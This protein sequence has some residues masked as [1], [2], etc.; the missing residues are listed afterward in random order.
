MLIKNPCSIC[1]FNVHN[2][3]KAIFCD[4]C[5]FWTHLKCTS[6]SSAEYIALSNSPEDWFCPSCIAELF[7][8]NQLDDTD[9]YFALYDFNSCCFD[10]EHLK[11]KCFNPFLDDPD[12]RHLLLN[13]DIDP[14]L[15]V[16]TNNASLLSNCIYL[17]SNEL[18]KIPISSS[19]AFS[20]FHIN[21][22]SLSKHFDD[23]SEYISTLNISFSAI[24]ISETWLNNST[25][26]LFNIPGYNFI[27]NIRQHKSGGGVGLY[28][29]SN[30][31]FKPRIDLQ[32]TD[33]RLYESI[34]AEIIQPNSRNIIVGCIYKPPDTSVTEFN[35]SISSIL[36]TIS[37]ENK[38]SYIMGDFN[39]NILNEN[40]QA[41]NDFINLMNSNCLYPAISKPTRV[42]PT[43]A[44]LI[45]GL[46]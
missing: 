46:L 23:L 35:N 7:P 19:N 27:S 44:T 22:H 11:D 26:H 45:D 32:S 33:N 6:F 14:N 39:I 30:L 3:H 10:S 28:I 2:N 21:I 5:Q 4:I 20:I 8:F 37:F 17:T 18:N 31:K 40:H 13:S 38:L 29:K 36:S 1:K 43:T 15:N 12:S 25:E 24:G 41:T 16:F 34:F 42:T 9:F